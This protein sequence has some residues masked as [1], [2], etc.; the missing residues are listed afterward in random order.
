MDKIRARVE[1]IEERM[2]KVNT[3]HGN[4]ETR[5]KIIEDKIQKMEENIE[6]R[7][8]TGKENEG[9]VCELKDKIERLE[10]S[11]EAQMETEMT[12]SRTALESPYLGVCSFRG[13]WD[14]HG[15]ITY[16]NIVSDF[17]NCDKPG[18]ACG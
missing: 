15:T 7:E 8:R 1:E 4:V 10:S 9:K 5:I 18:G 16:N 3:N 11:V 2:V 17:N 14:E 6:T 12:F 13:L